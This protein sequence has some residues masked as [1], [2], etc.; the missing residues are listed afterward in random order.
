[1]ERPALSQNEW[2]EFE[3]A[4]CDAIAA[5]VPGWTGHGQHDPGVTMLELI[6]YLLDRFATHAAIDRERAAPAVARIS[7][8]ASRLEGP[9]PFEVAVEGQR[10]TRVATLDGSGPDDRVFSIAGN[11]DVV[12]GDG[13]HGKRPP[14]GVRIAARYRH[15][16]GEH[17]NLGVTVRTT[18]PLPLVRCEISIKSEGV[19]RVRCA[20]DVDRA[21][22]G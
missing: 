8:A 13:L 22:S 4:V 2:A 6:A 5:C 18:W 11:T 15:G 20:S 1:M 9:S 14:E 7:D 17:G 12:F 10:W 21:R 16:A 3:S 19:I